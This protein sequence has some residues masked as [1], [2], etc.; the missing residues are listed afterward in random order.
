MAENRGLQALETGVVQKDLCSFCGACL[1]LCPYLRSWGGRWVKLHDCDLMEGRCYAYCPRTDLDLDSIHR[2]LLGGPYEA[3][4]M[5]PFRRVVMA[6]CT[7]PQVRRRAQ[8]GGVVS[9][10]V[11]LALDA[12]W[13]DTAVLTHRGED[14]LPEGCLARKREEVMACAGSSYVAA[15]TL[16]A[17]NRGPWNGDERIGIVAVPCQVQALAKM[18]LSDLEKKT[19]V[20]RITL[21]VGLFCTWA[22]TY[23]PFIEFVRV[24]V[25]G[26]RIQ[27]MDI[28]PPP[29][30]ILKVYTGESIWDIPLDEIRP[31]IPP[32][33]GVCLDMTSEWADLSVGTVEGME[34]W[35]TVVV[36]TQKGEELFQRA[37]RGGLLEVRQLPEANFRHLKEA[38]LL[39]KRRAL[40]T[41]QERGELTSGYLRLSQDAVQRI[42][43]EGHMEAGT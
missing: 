42:L 5:G 17:F 36:R 3:L 27:K 14:Q 28:T 38:S 32:T 40:R 30:R 37:E 7:D 21:I 2:G 19:P 8:T 25:Q 24:R 11:S 10:L 9:A 6:R 26:A 29:E 35:N 12:G 4:E 22:L 43:E 23:R 20:D 18:R 33:C 31:Y 39:K 1:S 34:D 41:L 13:I 16:E 15:P